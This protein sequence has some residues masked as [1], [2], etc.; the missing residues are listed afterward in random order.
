M[1]NI[2]AKELANYLIQEIKNDLKRS[3]L[4]KPEWV[5]GY[6]QALLAAI[7]FKSFIP[8]IEFEYWPKYGKVR[9]DV[10]WMEIDSERIAAVFEVQLENKSE[11]EEKIKNM[12]NF[13]LKGEALT[14]LSVLWLIYFTKSDVN[15]LRAL[16]KKHFNPILLIYTPPEN[17]FGV[18]YWWF[19]KNYSEADRGTFKL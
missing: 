8:I 5:H 18:L 1:E 10:V 19:Y 16:S 14:S 3:A 17:D 12:Y 2:N 6:L 13:L 4:K 15:D 9:P 7:G 11:A